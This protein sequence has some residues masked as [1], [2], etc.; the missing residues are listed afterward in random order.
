MMGTPL[1]GTF[2]TRQGKSLINVHL[3][4]T[5]HQHGDE[6]EWSFVFQYLSSVSRFP[7]VQA[8]LF[9]VSGQRTIAFQYKIDMCNAGKIQMN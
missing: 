2:K 1:L 7:K 9:N 4:T 5:L 8:D 6:A 3:G